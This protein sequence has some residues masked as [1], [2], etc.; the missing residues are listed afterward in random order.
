MRVETIDPLY[1][2]VDNRTRDTKPVLKEDTTW[3][4]GDPVSEKMDDRVALAVGAVQP[5]ELLRDILIQSNA[6]KA[7]ATHFEK[8]AVMLAGVVD[9]QAKRI[10]ELY[11]QNE[12]F[13]N[14]FWYCFGYYLGRLVGAL[15]G[16]KPRG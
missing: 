15:R 10:G 12:N 11:A 16:L 9:L 14:S 2:D 7:A 8:E 6:A 5:D 4:E 1:L 3:K 13:K